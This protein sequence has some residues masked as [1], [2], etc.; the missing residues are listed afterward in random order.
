LEKLNDQRPIEIIIAGY[1]AKVDKLDAS[2]WIVTLISECFPYAIK[3][4]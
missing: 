4:L 2:Q 1:G 3:N